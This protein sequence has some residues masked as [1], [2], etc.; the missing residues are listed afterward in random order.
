MMAKI[1]DRMPVIL[2]REDEEKWLDTSVTEAGRLLPLLSQ[3]D[4]D[5]MEMYAVSERV[6]S[7]KNNFPELL[8]PK[9]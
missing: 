9:D 7:P 1:H 8:L 3:Y 5:L 4:A 6:N 2:R